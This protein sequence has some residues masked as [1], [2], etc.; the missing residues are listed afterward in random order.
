VLSTSSQ[1]VPALPN[2]FLSEVIDC[3]TAK[4]NHHNVRRKDHNK[5]AARAVREARG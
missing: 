3:R 1:A 2:R 5:P 4:T